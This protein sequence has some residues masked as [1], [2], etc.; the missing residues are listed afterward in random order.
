MGNIFIL[1]P[2][3]VEGPDYYSEFKAYND[4]G[5]GT[6]FLGFLF[7]ETPV[8]NEIAALKNVTAEYNAS[9]LT[10]ATD[11]AVRVQEYRDK[12][13]ANGLQKVIDEMNAQLRVFYENK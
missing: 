9:L 3:D 7:D 2:Q 10:G 12:L 13:Y 11:P 6:T 5:V 8:R 4:A 1:T